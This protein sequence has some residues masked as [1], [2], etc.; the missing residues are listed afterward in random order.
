MSTDLQKVG[1]CMGMEMDSLDLIIESQVKNL[2]QINEVYNALGKVAVALWEVR[3][4][5]RS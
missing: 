4:E 3:G 2:G 5:W 1:D